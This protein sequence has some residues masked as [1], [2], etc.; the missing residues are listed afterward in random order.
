[1]ATTVTRSQAQQLPI[2]R[3]RSR[4]QW[5]NIRNGLL[6]TAP[7]IIGLLWFFAYPIAASF[8]YS[9]T[10]YDGLHNLSWAGLSNYVNL[11]KDSVF[12]TSL[13][14]TAYFVVFSVP[15]NLVTAF[16][17]ALL[18]NQRWIRGLAFFRTIFFIPSIVPLISSAVLFLWI[19]NPQYG[20]INTLLSYVGITGP[21]WLNDPAWAKPALIVMGLWS[22]GGWMVIFLAGLQN[23]PLEQYEAAEL[24]GAS[25]WQRLVHITLPFMSPY[26]LFNAINGLILSFQ[27]FLQPFVMTQGGPA[28]STTMYAVYLYQNAFQYYRMG[29]ASAMGWIL[30]VII[31]VLTYILFKSSARRVYYGGS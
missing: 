30:F 5:L 28:E 25:A 27:F 1:M 4:R 13:Y 6:F 16:L 19:F 18:L 3:R 29:Y 11:T 14:N 31:A 23:V 7:G 8:F 17:L 20:L 9:F 15:L 22:V 21:G 12:W 10:N 24:D 26:F 2:R